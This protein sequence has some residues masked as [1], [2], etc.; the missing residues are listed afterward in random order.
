MSG[1]IQRSNEVL[2]A[3][4]DDMLM[5]LS[6]KQGR[7]YGLKGVGP[8]IWELLEQPATQAGIVAQLLAEFEVPPGLC[9]E[10]VAGFVD[11]L[12]QRGLLIDLG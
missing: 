11:R 6:V 9:A 7:Y 8:R 10:Q 5:M 4:V 3:S 12:R 2:T 1:E